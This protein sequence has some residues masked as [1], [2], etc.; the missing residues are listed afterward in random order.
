MDTGESSSQWIQNIYAD[1]GSLSTSSSRTSK[2]HDLTKEKSTPPDIDRK[3][4]RKHK[5]SSRSGHRQ[6]KHT[7]R[8]RPSTQPDVA[9]QAPVVQDFL[10]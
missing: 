9:P 8:E 5:T 6:G 3:E 4:A 7:H 2:Q 10:L 1:T